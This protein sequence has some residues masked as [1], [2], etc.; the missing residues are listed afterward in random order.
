[1]GSALLGSLQ[2][3]CCLTEG[4]FGYSP[5]T[6]FYIPK[7]ARAYLFPQSVK[8]HYFCS[9]PISVDLFVRNH[10]EHRRAGLTGARAWGCARLVAYVMCRLP[11]HLCCR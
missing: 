1:M 8:N 9:G 5:L 2:I 11:L 3:S 4:L 6:Y 10:V 7:S